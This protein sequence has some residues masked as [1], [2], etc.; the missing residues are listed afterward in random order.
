MHHVDLYKSYKALINYFFGSPTGAP[1]IILSRL[2]IRTCVAVR[3]MEVTFNI[4]AILN[5]GFKKKH[6]QLTP[7]RYYN[8]TVL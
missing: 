4:D 7:E 5:M 1:H 6:Y 3:A 2:W 8:I